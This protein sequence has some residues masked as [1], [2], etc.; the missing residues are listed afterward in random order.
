MEFRYRCPNCGWDVETL[1]ERA[2]PD[3]GDACQPVVCPKCQQ[4]HSVNRANGEV[5]V[6]D[7]LGDPW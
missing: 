2:A 7:E 3:E 5:L 6:A 1:I 4:C